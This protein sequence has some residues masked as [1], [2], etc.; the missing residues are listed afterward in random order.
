MSGDLHGSRDLA[1]MAVFHT[2]WHGGAVKEVIFSLMAPPM[3][4]DH[5]WDHSGVSKWEEPLDAR[6]RIHLLSGGNKQTAVRRLQRCSSQTLRESGKILFALTLKVK[7]F[8]FSVSKFKLLDPVCA[9]YWVLN[10]DIFRIAHIFSPLQQIYI[11]QVWQ[12][13]GGL[14]GEWTI[15]RHKA[16]AIC[17]WKGFFVFKTLHKRKKINKMMQL[18]RDDSMA[19]NPRRATC[20]QHCSP[21]FLS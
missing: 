18:P 15:I 8:F 21:H 3:S 5:I 2:V 6:G 10:I 7:G 9:C 11:C 17:G 13:M 16:P 4:A 1:F 12:E 14:G 20:V 19:A